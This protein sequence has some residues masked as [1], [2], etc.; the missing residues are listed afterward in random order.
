MDKAQF[1]VEK[2][3]L[4]KQLEDWQIDQREYDEALEQLKKELQND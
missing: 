3:E 1:N 2:A 4:D